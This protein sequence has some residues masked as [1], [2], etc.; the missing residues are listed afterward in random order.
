MINMKRRQVNLKTY[1]LKLKAKKA[2]AAILVGVFLSTNTLSWAIPDNN[3]NLAPELRLNSAEFK[4]SLTVASICKHIELDGN[5]DDKSYLDDVLA[6]LDKGNSNIRLSQDDIIIEIPGEGL[7]IR[8]F[9]PAKANVVTPYSDISKL[10]TKVI[11]P[12]L[13]R[14]IIHRLKA[15]PAPSAQEIEKDKLAEALK[16]TYKAVI[17]DIDGTLTEGKAGVP[18]DLIDRIVNLINHNVYVVLTSGRAQEVPAEYAKKGIHSIEEVA[19]R[20]RAKVGDKGKLKYMLC[21]EEN[22]A[23]GV[24]GFSPQDSKRREFDLGI[25]KLEK[26]VQEEIFKEIYEKYPDKLLYPEYKKY[27]MAIW[28]KEQ[29]RTKEFTTFLANEVLKLIRSK[30]LDLVAVGTSVSVDIGSKGVQKSNS[31]AVLNKLYNIPEHQIATVGDQGHPEGNDHS[32]LE[33]KGGFCVGEYSLS[34]SS[35]ISLYVAMGLKSAAASR[36]LMDNLIF[37]GMKDPSKPDDLARNISAAINV[38]GLYK[39]LGRQG[40]IVEA[41][42]RVTQLVAMAYET[43]QATYDRMSAKYIQLRGKSPEG[44]DLEVLQKFLGLTRQRNTGAKE[45]SRILD[46]GTGLRDL[47][48]LSDQP[49][50]SAIGIDYAESVVKF[51]KKERQDA[52]VRRMD[53]LDLKFGDEEFDGVRFQATLHHLPVIDSEQGADMAVRETFRVLKQDGICYILVKSETDKRRGFMAVD[54]GEGLGARFYQFYSKESLQ[55]L[56]ERNGFH[57]LGDIEEWTDKRGE[58]NLIAF[59]KKLSDKPAPKTA[60]L[61]KDAAPNDAVTAPGADPL[62][63]YPEN[64]PLPANIADLPADRASAKYLFNEHGTLFDK[65]SA[66]LPAGSKDQLAQEVL[67]MEMM[68]ASA[69]DLE[70]QVAWA[71]RVL[72]LKGYGPNNSGFDSWYGSEGIPA[73]YMPVIKWHSINHWM[74]VPTPEEIRIIESVPGASYDLSDNGILVNAEGKTFR[75]VKMIFDEVARRLPDHGSD[76]ADKMAKFREVL[77]GRNRHFVMKRELRIGEEFFTTRGMYLK[78]FVSYLA[79]RKQTDISGIISI[80]QEI[81]DHDGVIDET[82][83]QKKL[84]DAVVTG[85][86]VIVEWPDITDDRFDMVSM[87]RE[88]IA[89]RENTITFRGEKLKIH[90]GFRLVFLMNDSETREL[91]KRVNNDFPIF[92]FPQYGVDIAREVMYD[93]FNSENWQK[94]SKAEA[95]AIRSVPFDE[96]LKKVVDRF[97]RGNADEAELIAALNSAF[98][99]AMRTDKCRAAF[100]RVMGGRFAL[101]REPAPKTAAPAKDIAPKDA[102][103]DQKIIEINGGKRLA[104]K[105]NIGGSKQD[106]LSVLGALLL[107]NGKVVIKNVPDITDVHNFLK[108]YESI[109][110]KYVWKGDTIEIDVDQNKLDFSKADMSSASKLRSSILLLGSFLARKG[111]AKFPKPGGCKIGERGFGEYKKIAESFG[112]MVHEDD[113]TLSGF[114]RN[115]DRDLPERVE[116]NY[117]PNKTALAMILA[118]AKRGTTYLINPSEYPEAYNLIS[119]FKKLGA[120]ISVTKAA[121]GDKE[122][123]ILKIESP[124]IDGLFN[125]DISYSLLPDKAEMTFW[126]AASAITRGDIVITSPFLSVDEHSLGVLGN[127][128]DLLLHELGIKVEIIDRH[129]VRVNSRNAHFNPVNIVASNSND[130]IDSMP[131]FIPLLAAINGISSYE[132]QHYGVNRVLFAEELNKMG[133]NITFRKNGSIEINGIEN[134]RG[135]AVEGKEIRGAACLVLAA[136][137]AQGTT[138]IKGVR[139]LMRGYSKLIEKLECLGSDI[140][141]GAPTATQ[142]PASGISKQLEYINRNKELF[143]S[144]LTEDRPDTLVRVPIEAIESIGIDRIKEF[145]AAFQEVPNGYIELYYMSGVGEV[146]ESIYQKKYGLQKKPLPKGFRRTRENTVTLFPALKGEEISQSKVVSRLGSV[147]ISPENTILSPIGLQHDPA[148]LIRATILGLKIMDIARKLKEKGVDQAFKDGINQDILHGL[149]NVCDVEDFDKFNLTEDDIIALARGNINDILVA[150]KKLVKLLPITPID[151]EELKQIYEHVKAVITAA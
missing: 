48:W 107:V 51:I 53:M 40:D 21:F 111:S 149:R 31:I 117:G 13:N 9:D 76:V 24:D 38:L 139:H 82:F 12:Q 136:L 61:E 67:W 20:I 79:G 93:L 11:S 150:L 123:T 130:G 143:K 112:I 138:K 65:A 113:M 135:A 47:S 2:L 121:R 17:F 120:N 142:D 94:R 103:I 98:K 70:P 18:D 127:N 147:D 151:T 44:K 66:L 74:R 146:A 27:S 105:V 87:I 60:A 88:L 131:H 83:I 45:K 25:R 78:R 72:A 23:T 29:Y 63:G 41:R 118:V 133:A 33:R 3:R 71:S 50:I 99:A 73:P 69:G 22:G 95:K 106:V 7:A 8:Y 134:L 75:E 80:G 122:E 140:K 116:I 84:K 26:K 96:D 5:L 108:I 119:F 36:W 148:G 16:K 86:A 46:V 49:E 109:G 59:A 34:K 126:M 145:L 125:G 28:V 104:G 6:R 77:T 68:G 129:T 30:G 97:H 114:K 110:V 10:Q 43:T 132:D 128:L 102:E 100:Q 56:L 101:P 42:K 64:T 91:V 55:K 14:Q 90:P 1:G 58:V 92:D 4:N 32:M 85:K 81:V 141:L 52:D 37:E 137:G 57:L 144:M 39:S 35:Q 15:L 19:S 54:T 124:G 89:A 115:A 62:F